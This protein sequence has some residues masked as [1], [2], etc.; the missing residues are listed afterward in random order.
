MRHLLCAIRAQAVPLARGSRCHEGDMT[1]NARQ[2]EKKGEM[3]GNK[4]VLEAM[5]KEENRLTQYS[6]S[7]I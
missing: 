4:Q 7:R 3:G 1:C 5:G 2:W 6:S